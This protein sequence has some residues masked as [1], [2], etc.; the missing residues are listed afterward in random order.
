MQFETISVTEWHSLIPSRK[1][2]SKYL[3]FREYNAYAS[4]K[5][6]PKKTKKN[7]ILYN[8]INC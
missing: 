2:Y 4:F 3:I 7:A 8:N 6:N 1:V 5:Q